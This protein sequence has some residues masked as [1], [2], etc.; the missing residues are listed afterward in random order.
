MRNLRFTVA[1]CF[2]LT[3]L[4]ASATAA[5]SETVVATVD[6]QPIYARD[7]ER[8]LSEVAAEKQINPAARPLVEAQVLSEIVDR[9]L[10]LA[11]ARRTRS[12]AAASEIE[13]ALGQIKSNLTAQGKSLDEYLREQSLSETDLRRRITWRLVWDYCLK[14]YITDGRLA[15]HFADHRRQ[16]DG[17]RVSVSHILLKSDEAGGPEATE[18][19]L[20]EAA[21]IRARITSG[22][23]S[24]A[25]A[26]Q[27]HSAGATASGGGR[28]GP[29]ERHGAMDEA[30]AR[31]AFELEVGQV[32]RP[33]KT[34]FGVHLIRCDK[35]TPGTRQQAEVRGELEESLARELLGKIAR[36]EERHTTV[37]FTGRAPYFK[38][39]T[40]ELVLP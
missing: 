23:T 38:P 30:F 22:E 33:V 28:L 7:V 19:L 18:K 29:I 8:M 13:A 27:R 40:R 35:I 2:Y 4:A 34:R 10:V 3:F 32:S 31:A 21:A 14:R 16:F 15:V 5:Q 12:G 25:E 11:Y 1:G 39:G 36:L 6:G 37:E 24:F 20:E 26:A 9:H 17:T